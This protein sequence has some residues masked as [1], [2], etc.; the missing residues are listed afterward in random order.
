M[1]KSHSFKET[2]VGDQ[3]GNAMSCVLPAYLLVFKRYSRVYGGMETW[4]TQDYVILLVYFENQ[5]WIIVLMLLR[6]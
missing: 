3:T 6:V 5:T 1:W 2:T 4:S